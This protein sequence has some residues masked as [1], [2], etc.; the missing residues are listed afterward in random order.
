METAP[1]LAPLGCVSAR[2]GPSHFARVLR[3]LS[4]PS[5]LFALTLF[6][7][8]VLTMCPGASLLGAADAQT[9]ITYAELLHQLTDLDRLTTLQTGCKGGLFSSW[10]RRSQT[11]WGANGDVGQYLR[12]ES[13]GEAVMMD[14]D[15]PGVVYRIWSANPMGK[16]RIYLDGAASPSY[17]WNFPDLFDGK[18]PPFIKPLVYRRDNPQS[19]SDCY[20]PI[21]FA[22][23]IKITAD[24]AHGEYYH[25]NYV[26]LPKE[27]SVAS[28]RLPLTAE[29]QAALSA[30]ADAWSNPGRDP[31]PRLPGQTTITRTV[32]IQP[33]QSAEICEI[34]EP[35]VIRAIKARVRSE[36][37]YPWRKLVLRGVWDG[38]E[39]PQILTPLGPFF[40]FDWEPAE[41]GSVPVGC[42]NGQA[43]QFFPMPFRKS[44]RFS[45]Q[46]SLE[47]PAT[48]EFEFEYAP[49]ET[50]ADNSLY[51]YARWRHEP[52]IV[53]FDYP[54][55][56]TAGRGHF[57]G[58]S[59]PIE[60][61]LDGWW[62][63]GD[64][65]VWVDDDDFPPYIG[66]GSED[67]FGDAWGIRY[68]SGPSFGASS[69]TGHRT[70][71]Y[72]WHF[73]DFI[74]FTKRMRMTIENYG[75]N[76]VGPRGQYDYSSTAFWYQAEQT[77]PF[78][79]LRGV[80]FT[81]GSD[82]AAKPVTMEY[83]QSVFAE[84]TP[85]DLR[86]Y[87]LGLTFA[88]Q[89][90]TLLADAVD[91]GKA[92]I[93][94][95][96]L[97]PY[98]FD[99]ERAVA[100]GK[101]T[102]G[103]KLAAFTICVGSDG[104]Y[105]PRIHTAPE[106]GIADL[107]LE[108]DGDSLSIS[109]KPSPHELQLQGVFLTKGEHLVALIAKSAG[110]AVFDCLQLQPA[111]RFPEAIEAEELTV[112]RTTGGAQ[113]PRASDPI[114]DVSA[115]R[116]LGFVASE[117]GNGF[118]LR[119]DQRPALPYVL[120][121]RPMLSPSAGIIR[122]FV[123]GKPIGPQF[124]LYAAQRGLGPSIVP[125]G[126]VPAGCSEV[127]IRVIGCNP[128]STGFGVELDYLRWEPTILGP[129][130]AE[131]I[132]AQ[133]IGKQDCD[134]HGQDLGSSYSGGHQLWVMPCNLNGWLDIAL[135]IP[136]AG[137]YEISAKY[138]KSWDYAKIQATLDGKP[139]GPVVDTF[140][141]T[142]VP[143][144]TIILGK[145]NLSTGRHVLRFQAV[146]HNPESKGYLMGIDHVT[147]K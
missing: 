69:M 95:D 34:D 54:F 52:D 61:P 89:A 74:P 86:T 28:F 25:F 99:R 56:E 15:G 31:K 60:H 110:E 145:L 83:S 53:R 125:L 35:G 37:R 11:N 72:R 96:A 84:I 112:L 107:S 65:M 114:N 10:D 47:Q 143:G 103:Q 146:G 104:V 77:P 122:A 80:K 76:G 32:T 41:Y 120:G 68:L 46:S 67:Y 117:V 44:A 45:I 49:R 20:L 9:P 82:P 2:K 113:P 132:W 26:T 136:K 121:A 111:K 8:V 23:H 90:E 7:T 73:M 134:Y 97:R 12:V 6:S 29:E 3:S 59:M 141:P 1:S 116:V 139:L 70:C 81:G 119:L 17:E 91:R 102:A 144:D 4:P 51:F 87:G 24:K 39:W 133:V 58:V 43:Y 124:D 85:Q 142:V 130:S 55:L 50:L 126:P 40:G 135:E 98:E 14:L 78:G 105:H 109:A 16:L 19:A 66:T 64:E 137:T 128:H 30:A 123:E 22:K 57:V 13:N 5:R 27:R 79:Q 33:G 92:K 131:E 48:V 21:P 75:P 129:D 94:T 138:T 115:G 71:N 100:L 106:P 42:L 108:V 88:Q 127:E 62:G 140:A 118:V 18:L 38:A 101:A 63:E 36:Q 93:V 147:V